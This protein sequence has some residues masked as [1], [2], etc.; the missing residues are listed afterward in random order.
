MTYAVHTATCSYLLDEDGICRWALA[1][2]GPAPPAAER[3]VGA[4]FVACLDLHSEGGLVGELR[5]GGS[6]LF[7]R[8]EGGRFV[9]LRTLPIVNVEIRSAVE[10]PPSFADTPVTMGDPRRVPQTPPVVPREALPLPSFDRPQAPVAIHTPADPQTEPLPGI[11]FNP[12]ETEIL[13]PRWSSPG[14]PLDLEDLLSI[15]VTELTLSLP[16]YRL[17]PAAPPSRPPPLPSSRPVAMGDP[18]RVPQT[19][20]APSKPPPHPPPRRRPP[21]PKRR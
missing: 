17:P 6:A 3:C 2:G 10:D 9:L 14:E 16:L 21:E 18:R 4:Q 20:P 11:A 12:E 7:V 8:R 15:S 1:P 5:I 19:P 13:D